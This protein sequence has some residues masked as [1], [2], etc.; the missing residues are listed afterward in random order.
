[1]FHAALKSAG[2]GAHQALHIGD[3][4]EEDIRA[5]LDTGFDAIWANLLG[6]EW[7]SHL[8]RHPHQV[9]SLTE[10]RQLIERLDQ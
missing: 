9:S 1:M 8:P 5:A 3:H 6:L 2:A 7:P 4:P 10:L